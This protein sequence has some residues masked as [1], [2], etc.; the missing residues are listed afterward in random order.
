M[1][2]FEIRYYKY[3]IHDNIPAVV[4]RKTGLTLVE[5]FKKLPLKVLQDVLQFWDSKDPVSRLEA[6]IASNGTV[7]NDETLIYQLDSIDTGGDSFVYV[8]EKADNE[9]VPVCGTD[10]EYM[11]EG[12]DQEW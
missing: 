6:E 12:E 1:R 5:A 8:L 2:K 11:Q 4:Y 7:L 9:L 10:G 3:H